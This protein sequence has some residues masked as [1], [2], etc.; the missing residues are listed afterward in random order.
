MRSLKATSHI[1]VFNKHC[2]DSREERLHCRVNPMSDKY[3]F[4]TA[5]AKKNEGNYF[6]VLSLECSMPRCAHKG[7][8]IHCQPMVSSRSQGRNSQ[9]RNIQVRMRFFFMK[10]PES[11]QL[12]QSFCEKWRKQVGLRRGARSFNKTTKEPC[13]NICNIFK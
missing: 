13:K 8:K 6:F 5:Q 4:G 2:N 7:G 1:S 12:S 9:V 3:S 10:L 11:K